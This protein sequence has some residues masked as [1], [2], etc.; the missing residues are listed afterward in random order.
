MREMNIFKGENLVE[1]VDKF[2][3]DEVCKE[4]LSELKWAENYQ[5]KKCRNKKYSLKPNLSRV[6]TKCHH[7]ESPSANTLF[8]KVKF[9]LRKA[10]MIAFEMSATTKGLSASQVAK[11]YGITRKTAWF[12]MQKVRISMHSSEQ[13]PMTG[14]VHV[15]EFVVG[16]KEN[17][18]QGRSND[19]KKKKVVVAVELTK[20][21]KVKRAYSMCIKDYSSSSLRQIFEKHISPNAS[22]ITDE[23]TGYKPLKGDYKI[24]QLPSNNGLNFKQ[25]H[26]VVHQIKTWIR[27]TYS[28]THKQH[29]DKYLD[30]YSFRINRSIYKDSIF[31]KLIERMV[32]A[33][34]TEYKD[35]II[36]AK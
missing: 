21:N 33:N 24:T 36:G 4:Y 23:W 28:W 8:H 31:H 25:L 20:D 2:N 13:H 29:T 9:G 17:M 15:D 12:F 10:F 16:G 14:I 22:I 32:I 34:H 6:C 11:R 30:E 3:S 5:C 35:I 19:T 1:F 18:K 7:T 26:N 27:T